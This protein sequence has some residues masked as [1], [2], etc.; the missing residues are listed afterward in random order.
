MYAANWYGMCSYVL[1]SNKPGVGNAGR[2]PNR[3]V[4]IN[5]VIDLIQEVHIPFHTHLQLMNI[6]Q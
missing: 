2:N 5:L 6:C 3:S 4:D 1:K